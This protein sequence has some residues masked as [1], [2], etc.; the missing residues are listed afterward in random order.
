MQAACRH[1]ATLE[2]TIKAGSLSLRRR[3]GANRGAQED[4]RIQFA[5]DLRR[6]AHI[7]ALRKCVAAASRPCGFC[8]IWLCGGRETFSSSP[9]MY[10][11]VRAARL[12]CSFRHT[13]GQH[14]PE[15]TLA[16]EQTTALI[17]PGFSPSVVA[18]FHSEHCAM[19]ITNSSHSLAWH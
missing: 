15:D 1:T 5:R 17:C 19:P 4:L 12:P 10:T 14:V 13:A 2:S 6:E 7:C 11:S 8:D 16:E 3:E 18:I 9:C